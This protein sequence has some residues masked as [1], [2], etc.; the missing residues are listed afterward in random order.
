MPH[1]TDL[2]VQSTTLTTLHKRLGLEMVVDFL[3]KIGFGHRAS[4]EAEN[5]EN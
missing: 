4:M 5:E 1:C 3:N 2:V